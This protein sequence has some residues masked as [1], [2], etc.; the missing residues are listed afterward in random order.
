MKKNV[1]AKLAVVETPIRIDIGCGKNKKE[2][3]LGVDQ[4]S[5]DG[6]DFVFNA[7]TDPWPW[8]DDSV[9]EAHCSHFLEHLTNQNGR[10]ERVHFF[11]ELY[12]VLKVG[13]QCRLII[14]HWC[15][16][17]YYGDP[18]HC[19]PFSEMGFYYLDP[20]WRET[21]APH[22]D[23]RWNPHGYNC[24]FACGW[25]YHYRNEPHLVGRNQEYIDRFVAYSKEIITDIDCTMTKRVQV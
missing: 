10:W 11:N 14:P 7:G 17:R 24:D 1:K 21:Q 6:V 19:E 23:S 8:A 16:N 5:F 20:K 18:T 9:E 4:F 15:S 12:R 2:G 3:F 25:N 22:A 13:A